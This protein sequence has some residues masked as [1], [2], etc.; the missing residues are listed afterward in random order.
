MI[1]R[2]V[3]A[4]PELTDLSLKYMSAALPAID[5]LRGCSAL[6]SLRL[7]PDRILRTLHPAF[8]GSI[9]PVRQSPA[10]HASGIHPTAMCWQELGLDPA[11]HVLLAKLLTT[12]RGLKHLVLG[13]GSHPVSF[14]ALP[15]GLT[16]LLLA[17]HPANVADHL[18]ALTPRFSAQLRELSMTLL[19][20]TPAT[21]GNP[22]TGHVG[23]GLP[24]VPKHD[25]TRPLDL[26]TLAKLRRLHLELATVAHV[27]S[28]VSAVARPHSMPT[29]FHGPT[30][31][32]PRTLVHLSI[33]YAAA[34][35]RTC[36]YGTFFGPH[37]DGTYLA[38]RMLTF[39]PPHSND[40]SDSDDGYIHKRAAA[41]DTEAKADPPR[42]RSLAIE[43]KEY[44]PGTPRVD[45]LCDLL[46]DGEPPI[47]FSP[48]CTEGSQFCPECLRFW[49]ALFRHAASERVALQSFTYAG[50]VLSVTPD[51]T[52]LVTRLME[53][54]GA[55][56]Q[57]IDLSRIYAWRR[58]FAGPEREELRQ[59]HDDEMTLIAEMDECFAEPRETRF[60]GAARAEVVAGL[61]RAREAQAAKGGDG[62][63]LPVLLM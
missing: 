52:E 3:A 40:A 55:S 28:S 21:F 31:R 27:S 46:E 32:L 20:P 59:L 41:G 17:S 7:V 12:S 9:A 25:R 37:R 39:G 51:L 22:R 48:L 5:E 16:Q 42:L 10:A 8:M 56:L 43:F 34:L 18:P 2:A 61:R 44:A 23:E 60:G 45:V 14:L 33:C 54:H 29:A 58:S 6:T 50:P 24:E 63:E 30:L 11:T 49:A 62:R 1:F 38:P 19:Y 47:N 13:D 15:G 4:L 35:P 36:G 53:H 26:S 57:R